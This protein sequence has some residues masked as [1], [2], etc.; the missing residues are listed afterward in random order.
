MAFFYDHRFICGDPDP[1]VNGKR[2]KRGEFCL[3]PYGHSGSHL[4]CIPPPMA[5][6]ASCDPGGPI[7]S[8]PH[9]PG[10]NGRPATKETAKWYPMQRPSVIKGAAPDA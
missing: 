9:A 10:C 2:P 7:W 8:A 6:L 1:W 4:P 5:C 3:A